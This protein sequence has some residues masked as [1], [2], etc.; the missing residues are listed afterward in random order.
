MGFYFKNECAKNREV[1]VIPSNIPYAVYT[2][3]ETVR[4][5]DV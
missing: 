4:T 1:I 5:I 3:K 2:K